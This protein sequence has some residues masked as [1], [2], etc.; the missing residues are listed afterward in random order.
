MATDWGRKHLRRLVLIKG[1][2]VLASAKRYDLQAVIGGRTVPLLGIGAVFT[3]E[4]Q[5]GRGHARALID[6]M[7]EDAISR[8]CAGALLF[9]EIG[10][11]YYE[12]A[13]F[14]AIRRELVSIEV[15]PPV[16]RGAPATFVRSGEARD[17]P[18]IA[19]ISA[20]YR[21]GADFALDRSSDFIAFMLARRR[22]QAGLGPA[23]LRQVEFFVSEEGHRPVAYVVVSRGPRGVVLEDCGDNDPTG[24]RIGSMLQVMAARTPA[25]PDPQLSAWLPLS[26][27]PPQLVVSQGTPAPE[28]MMFRP[29][30]PLASSMQT[31]EAL[32]PIVYWQ[33]DVF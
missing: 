33:M 27:R 25:E 5:R 18:F 28:I 29:L 23:G 19:E 9:S 6:L 26:L 11:D 24:A 31:I 2:T 8:Q 4:T 10:R 1:E 16:T 20:R 7:I 17:L 15:R 3:P 21:N 13:G 32:S 12:R 14:H 30:Q 22:L